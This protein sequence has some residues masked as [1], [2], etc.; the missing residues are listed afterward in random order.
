MRL[1]FLR[2]KM[3][4]RRTRKGRW[5]GEMGRCVGAFIFREGRCEQSYADVERLNLKA[6]N[7]NAMD[8]L[9][10]IACLGSLEDTF[11]LRD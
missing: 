1:G 9:L 6:K 10:V 5:E 7:A 11:R 3:K 8:N 2:G 4:V